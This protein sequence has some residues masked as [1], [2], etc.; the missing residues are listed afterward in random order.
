MSCLVEQHFWHVMLSF[1]S[2][3]ADKVLFPSTLFGCEDE[4]LVK[5][6][7]PVLLAW[8][9]IA[10]VG[11]QVSVVVSHSLVSRVTFTKPR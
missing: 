8:L 7:Y 2:V 3:G 10:I 1:H 5:L 11:I 6:T 4:N 9:V